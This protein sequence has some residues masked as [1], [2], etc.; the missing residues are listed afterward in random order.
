M[1]LAMVSYLLY[2]VS[3]GYM[4]ETFATP[5]EQNEKEKNM[6]KTKATSCW[7]KQGHT[8]AYFVF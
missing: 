8:S 5:E 4:P 7:V 6:L 1:Q 3:Y 2:S